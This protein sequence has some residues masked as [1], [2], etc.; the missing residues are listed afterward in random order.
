MQV[1]PQEAEI[2]SYLASSVKNDIAE[3]D[4]SK[5]W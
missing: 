3:I 1:A 4:F 2:A 5:I